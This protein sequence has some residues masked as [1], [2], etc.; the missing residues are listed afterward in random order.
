[1]P[2]AGFLFLQDRWAD[3]APDQSALPATTACGPHLHP[4]QY[5]QPGLEPSLHPEIHPVQIAW[6]FRASGETTSESDFTLAGAENPETATAVWSSVH[7]VAE[8][9]G[10]KMTERFD[11]HHCQKS[12]FG[13]KYVLREES[14][15]CVPCFEDL[16]AS[17][18][19]ECGKPIGCDCKLCD[20]ASYAAF[21]DGAA[22]PQ[23]CRGM[24]L[25]TWMDT[26]SPDLQQGCAQ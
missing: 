20:M 8:H 24:E 13:K 6:L 16:Y 14:P 12:L 2:G 3:E 15:Y 11:C 10:A 26:C 9:P 19:E 18:C 7:Q 5:S 23:D 4:T 21:E 25:L 1:M 17:T 22:C